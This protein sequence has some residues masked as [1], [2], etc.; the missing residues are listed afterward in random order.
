MSHEWAIKC[1]GPSLVRTNEIPFSKN[2]QDFVAQVRE[3]RE[4]IGHRL[5]LTGSS[6]QLTVVPKVIG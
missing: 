6:A 1:A 2:D 3:T 5:T 4:E